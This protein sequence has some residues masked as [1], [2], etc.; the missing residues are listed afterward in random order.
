MVC[1]ETELALLALPADMNCLVAEPCTPVIPKDAAIIAA[2]H[3]IIRFK[4]CLMIE[5]HE[6]YAHFISL[7]REHFTR[8]AHQLLGWARPSHMNGV[9]AHLRYTA[10]DL[11][12]NDH[13]LLFGNLADTKA[14]LTVWDMDTLVVRSDVLPQ[15]CVQ[16]SPYSMKRHDNGSLPFIMQLSGNEQSLYDDIMQSLA[17]LTMAQKPD[18]VIWWI[19]DGTNSKS[20]LMDAL[21]SIFPDQLSSLT[22]KQLVG[23]RSNTP[24]LNGM[25]GNIAKDDNGQVKDVELYRTISKHHDF[26]VH[27][28]HSQDGLEVQGNV[29]HIFSADNAPTFTKKSWSTQWRTFT[30]PFNE[31]NESN[32]PYTFTPEMFGQLIAEMCVYAN[33]IKRQGYRYEWSATTLA[34]KNRKLDIAPS[35]PSSIL[36]GRW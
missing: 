24:L 35:R 9:F 36:A 17:P 11:S 12:A 20:M 34:A 29:H 1:D 18:G 30:V 32:L 33:H 8:I 7:T 16:R 21:F 15:D 10:Q 3:R 25:L 23:G 31:Q 2:Q 26:N 19:G 22:V 28:Y 5:M 27:K 6:P 13:L 4:G 14:D